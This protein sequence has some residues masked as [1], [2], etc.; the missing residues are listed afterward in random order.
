VN[1]DAWKHEAAVTVKTSNEHVVV[2]GTVGIDDIATPYA[3]AAEVLGG[4]ATYAS[5]AARLFARSTLL[6]VVG[7]DFPPEH[8]ALLR[9]RSINLSGLE[10][11]EG[12][13]FRWGGRYESN[14]NVRETTFVD[15]NVLR[16]F[17][18]TVPEHVTISSFVFLGNTDPA[19]QLRVLDQVEDPQFVLVDS[20]DFWIQ[21]DWDRLARVVQRC[22]CVV[23]ND[24][25]IRL[26][27][28]DSNIPRA[29]Q[30]ILAM[31]PSSV[32]V[33][34]GEHG[35]LLVDGDGWF[36]APGYPLGEVVDPT[37]AGDAFAG[38]FLGSLAETS[39]SESSALR[40]AV[41]YGSVAASFTVEALGVNRLADLTRDEVNARYAEFGQFVAF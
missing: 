25:E 20:M 33:K 18:P 2:I 10:H 1:G 38:A 36:F 40:R 34:R 27:G 15:L 4:S 12:K 5:L 39:T 23:L 30:N 21:S 13:T 19:I 11:A 14:M 28:R 17:D 6:S 9:D 37:G 16:D 29:A 32:V 31:G 41:V 22:T 35:A 24:E 8:E 26:F 7:T 3:Q